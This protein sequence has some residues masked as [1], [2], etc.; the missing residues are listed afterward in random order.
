M[1]TLKICRLER[2]GLGGKKMQAW[3]DWAKDRLLAGKPKESGYNFY[4]DGTKQ[5]IAGVWQCT[6]GMAEIVNFPYDEF[7]ILLEGSVVIADASGHKETYGPGDAFVIPKGFNGT[8]SMPVTVRKYYVIFEDKLSAK[9]AKATKPVPAGARPAPRRV[10][11]R[12]AASRR[13]AA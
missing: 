3:G 12:R 6:P 5:L 8:W 7:C 4:T 2:G 10:V 11:A 13:R 1:A 9:L